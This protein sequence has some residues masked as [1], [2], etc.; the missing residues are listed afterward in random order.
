[1]RL[2][3]LGIVLLCA[4]GCAKP[5]GD[6]EP[7]AAK[8]NAYVIT[9]RE[10]DVAYDRA[11]GVFSN[12]PQVSPVELKA[13]VL[14]E[15]I[16]NQLLVEEA[17]R[18]NMDKSPALMREIEAYWRQSLVKAVLDA[19]SK[20]FS[21]VAGVSDDAARARLDAWIASLRAKATVEVR[22]DR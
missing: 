13:N 21:S 1:M 10:L 19:K 3:A 2:I 4:A 17:Q 11:A 15:M 22:H 8:V 18:M 20:E 6:P 5:Q 16:T 9:Q 14:E 12:F 7:A